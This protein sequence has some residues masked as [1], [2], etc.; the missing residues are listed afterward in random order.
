[1]R[2]FSAASHVRHNLPPSASAEEVSHFAELADSWWDSSGPQRILHKMNLLRVDYIRDILGTYGHVNKK[3]SHRALPGYSLDLLPEEA[4]S[5]IIA[6]RLEPG[7]LDENGQHKYSVLDIGCGGGLLAES[8]ARCHFVKKVL[9]IDATPEVIE[10]AEAH[11]KQDPALT[12]KKLEYRNIGVE[13]LGESADGKYDIL[14][15][16]EILE[17]VAN[18]D[19][20]LRQA[21]S[22]VKKGGFVFLSTINRTPV[23]YLTTILFGEQLLRIVPK[24]THTWSKYLNQEELKNWFLKEGGWE[25]V[26][27]DGC[28][29]VPTLG[30]KMGGILGD[31]N[32]GN[33]FAVYRKL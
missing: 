8:L 27:A 33:Y 21:V 10:V 31:K 22:K 3:A 15:L 4:R 7:Q 32:M 25:F 6:D 17:H 12:L 5:R 24:G 29:Y 23:S 11:R 26:Q 16:F 19:E 13:R 1:M 14:T 9:A 2:N 28:F 30:W 18:P 20:F